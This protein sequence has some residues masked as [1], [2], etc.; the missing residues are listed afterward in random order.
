MLP[1]IF[2]FFFSFFPSHWLTDLS[3]EHP[4]TTA[5]FLCPPSVTGHK[6]VYLVNRTGP[7]NPKLSTLDEI[8]SE[9]TT[10]SLCADLE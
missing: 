9:G 7:S 4:L 5:V 2:F 6:W 1:R 8:S 10:L 3:Y